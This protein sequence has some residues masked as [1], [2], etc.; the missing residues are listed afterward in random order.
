MSMANT[1]LRCGLRAFPL[2]LLL[3]LLALLPPTPSAATD[4]RTICFAGSGKPKIDIVMCTRALMPAKALTRA[5]LLM[6]R[7]RARIQLKDDARAL[8][9]LTEALAINPLSSEALTE[10]ARALQYL[11]RPE[12]AFTALNEALRIS[13]N[14]TTARTT[15]G[16]LA[17]TL[18]DHAEA[19]KDLSMVIASKPGSGESHA[20]RGIAHY[21]LDNPAQSLKDFNE[22][23]ARDF[24]YAYLPLWIALT[25]ERIGKSGKEILQRARASLLDN[26]DWPA[27]V[28]AMYQAPGPSTLAIALDA[29]SRGSL[30]LRK[31]RA[32]QIHFLQAELLRLADAAKAT[33]AYEAAIRDGDPR[34]VEY[35]LAQQRL[36]S[37]KKSQS[38]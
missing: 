31:A 30:Q 20:L 7:A 15:R 2:A 26:Q 12:E 9:D 6:R 17:L 36:R 23:A 21:F 32:G 28:I 33:Q 24:G 34:T 22:A 38:N 29:A 27:P 25:R 35:A 19:I 3:V 18:G 1:D 4:P 11:G 8:K 37:G 13:P 5:T 16:V 14:N 10:K